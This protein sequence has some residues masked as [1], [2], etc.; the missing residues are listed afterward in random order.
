MHNFKDL[1]LG[2]SYDDVLLVPQ[3]SNVESRSDV[4][5]S[6]QITPRVK[7]NIP[8]ISINMTDVTGV[9]MAVALGKLGGIGFLPRFETPEKQAEMVKDVKKQ[10]V[11]VGAA[12]GC[13]EGYLKRAEMLANAGA[14][15]LTLDVAHGGMIQAIE[16]TGELKRMFGRKCD[17]VSGVIG[18]YETAY[19][20]YKAGADSVRVGV[21]PGTIC[22]TRIQTGV[23]VPQ[24]T[25]V[26]EA[27]RAAKHFN[28]ILPAQKSGVSLQ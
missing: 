23:G 13:R 11:Y 4:D 24:I 6:T 28:D 2:L 26:A 27:Y 12:V 7:L 18:T 21:G 22:I 1:L 14:D 20:L 15:I 3:I 9:E 10:N 25:A 19:A 8:L 16:A 5:L 17:I